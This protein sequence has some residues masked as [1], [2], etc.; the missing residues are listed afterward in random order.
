MQLSSM[1]RRAQLEVWIGK[2]K[3]KRTR[4]HQQESRE[5]SLFVYFLKKTQGNFAKLFEVSLGNL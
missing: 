2:E 1:H 3:D 5:N 4:N